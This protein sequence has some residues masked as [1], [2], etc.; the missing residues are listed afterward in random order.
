MKIA[1][2]NEQCYR[3]IEFYFKIKSISKYLLVK[4]VQNILFKEYY[5]NCN[6]FIQSILKLSKEKKT[7]LQ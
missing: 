5:L 4:R 1:N 7:I 3:N 2:L 6:S